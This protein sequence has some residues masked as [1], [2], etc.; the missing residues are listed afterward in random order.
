MSTLRGPAQLADLQGTLCVFAHYPYIM[1]SFKLDLPLW[2]RPSN[3]SDFFFRSDFAF[4]FHRTHNTCS[5]TSGFSMEG[6]PFLLQRRTAVIWQG[7]LLLVTG[8]VRHG[9]HLPTTCGRHCSSEHT[10]GFDVWPHQFPTSWSHRP[11]RSGTA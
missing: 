11:L 10:P 2:Q 8:H 7:A 1:A 9:R 3:L 6:A 4:D 5:F